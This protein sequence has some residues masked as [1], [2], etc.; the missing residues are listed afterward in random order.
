MSLP[1]PPSRSKTPTLYSPGESYQLI[2]LVS[3]GFLFCLPHGSFSE[4]YKHAD[5]PHFPFGKTHL[6]PTCEGCWLISLP[7]RPPF[8]KVLCASLSLLLPPCTPHPNRASLLDGRACRQVSSFIPT[9]PPGGP[10]HWFLRTKPRCSLRLLRDPTWRL[11]W[12]RPPERLVL[13]AP[14]VSQEIEHGRKG[15][16]CPTEEIWRLVV[17]N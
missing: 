5:S 9:Q 7:V 13:K 4:T 3:C 6:D 12:G 10:E 8:W 1:G 2:S 14:Q 11:V 16:G 17:L 15:I